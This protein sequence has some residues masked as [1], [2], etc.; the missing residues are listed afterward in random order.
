MTSPHPGD[1]PTAAAATP[2]AAPDVATSAEAAS[3]PPDKRTE[4]PHPLTPLIRGWVVLVALVLAIGRDYL[5][6]GTD[7]PELPRLEFILALVL[8]AALAAGVVGFFSWYATRF[9]IDQDEL[10]VETGMVFRTSRRIAFQR[11]QAIDL[12]QPFAARIF[13]LA[14]LR[15]DIGSEGGTTLRYLALQR[16]HTL[17]DYLLGRVHGV[18]LEQTDDERV[19]VLD[20]LTTRDE[21]LV[22]VPPATLAVAAVTSPEF[23]W[24]IAGSVVAAAMAVWLNHPW[25]ALGLGIPTLSA[26]VGFITRRVTGQFNF[27]L[28]RRP[29]GLRISRGLTSLTSQSV[30]NRRVQAIQVSRPVLWRRL[31]LFGIDIGVIGRADRSEEADAGP[32]TTL[33]PAGTADQVRT[34]VTALWPYA[35]P[36]AVPLRP[37]PA[38]ARWLHPFAGGFLAWGYDH[39]VVATRH[40][41]LVRRWQYVPH[42]RAQSIRL[43]Q[44]PLE[45]WLRLATLEIHTADA[46]LHVR[47]EGL[48]ELAARQAVTELLDHAHRRR[49][50][51]VA[52]LPP[53][54]A[55]PSA[56]TA[57]DAQAA[58]RRADQA[59]ATISSTE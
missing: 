43:S 9:V 20:D 44:G 42:A 19:S 37:A 58:E 2:P 33:L 11:V 50:P 16:A 53:E 24:I 36:E 18:V 28:S 39:D 4:R 14:E 26:L 54:P 51:D 38:R 55:L 49:R 34:A 1:D 21:V 30:P 45:R 29:T 13:G 6:D 8:L 7:R 57:P 5:P 47:A 46:H 3:S 56:P 17:R 10:R 12:V 52:D 15:I 59:E 23:F 41:W 48:D 40:G 32:G 31:G 35:H 27:T 22:R 25:I